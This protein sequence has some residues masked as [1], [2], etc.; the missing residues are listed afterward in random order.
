MR[1]PCYC[2]SCIYKPTKKSKYI[3]SLLV[4]NENHIQPIHDNKNMNGT[5]SLVEAISSIQKEYKSAGNYKIQFV[6]C[7]CANVSRSDRKKNYEKS[8]TETRILSNGAIKKTNIL[9]KERRDMTNKH[10]LKMKQ[11][12]KYKT[13]DTAKKQDLLIKKAEQY[14]TMMLKNKIR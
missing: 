10:E 7:L 1:L 13:M 2:I 6:S 4:C 14:K 9:R 5:A 3:Y 11:L 8:E 12:Q